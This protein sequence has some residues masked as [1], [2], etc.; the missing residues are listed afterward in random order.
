VPIVVQ[1]IMFE[2][3]VMCEA[4]DM[5]LSFAESRYSRYPVHAH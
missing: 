2:P 3:K 1:E 5:E 4:V